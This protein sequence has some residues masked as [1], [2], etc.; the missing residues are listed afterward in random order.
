MTDRIV[1]MTPTD[2]MREAM[3][4]MTPERHAAM[5]WSHGEYK[6]G[7]CH[8]LMA[9]ASP[10]DVAAFKAQAESRGATYVDLRKIGGK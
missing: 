9:S 5:G 3:H 7:Y 10:E 4:T 1:T 8:A 2:E 6:D